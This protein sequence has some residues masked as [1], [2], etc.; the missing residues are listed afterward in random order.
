MS[1]VLHLMRRRGAVTGTD[2]IEAT[3]LARATVIAVCDDLIKAGWVR[4][5]PAQKIVPHKGRPARVFEFNATAG[6]VVGLD[7]GVA[8]T[9]ALLTDL[10]GNILAKESVPLPE[11]SAPDS[12]RINAIDEAIQ[13]VLASAEVNPRSVLVAVLGIAAPVDR[14]GKIS[15]GQTFWERLDIGIDVDLQARY[16]WPVLLENDANLA[17]LAERWMGVGQGIDDLAVMLAGE[18]IGFGLVASGYLLHGATGRS[19]E[20]GMLQLVEGV[21]TPE[22][23]A[24]LARKMAGTT[25]TRGAYDLAE[26]ITAEHVFSAA[27]QGDEAALEILGAI[28]RRMAR[29]IAVTATLVDPELV[30]IAG[31]VAQSS[32]ALLKELEREL[33][34][35]MPNPPRVALSTLGDTIVTLGA[36]RL[37][38]DY[39]QKHALEMV[40]S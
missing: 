30:V 29:V 38:L 16:G 25:R 14:A 40:L 1:A 39:V 17:A 7:F 3:G 26:P 2:L 5:L 37:A 10:R 9:T 11:F 21:G 19:G 36:V 31:A 24:A 6:Y 35:L 33:A 18:R 8:K 15:H 32:T 28:A 23:I 12:A 13:S 27:V 4:E 20:M 22:G 34:T